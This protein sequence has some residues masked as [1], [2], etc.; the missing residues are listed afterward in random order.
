[1]FLF[2]QNA[3]LHVAL[4]VFLVLRYHLT[5]KK[6]STVTGGGIQN[7]TQSFQRLH[8][9]LEIRPTVF[10]NDFLFTSKMYWMYL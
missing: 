2:T 5:S 8:N 4:Y 10:I 6:S 3:S 1:M 7:K 9:I